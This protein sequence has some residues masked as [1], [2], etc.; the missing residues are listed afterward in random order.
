MMR[1]HGCKERDIIGVLTVATADLVFPIRIN[2]LLVGDILLADTI[3][4]SVDDKRRSLVRTI[5][6]PGLTEWQ[7]GA[8]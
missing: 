7:E 4:R 3:F 5:R 1:D 2:K 8:A 6:V